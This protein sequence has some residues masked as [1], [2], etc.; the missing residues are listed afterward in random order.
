MYLEILLQMFAKL[1]VLF[2]TFRADVALLLD[3]RLHSHQKC[4]ANEKILLKD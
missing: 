2:V 3:L 4:D 1:A